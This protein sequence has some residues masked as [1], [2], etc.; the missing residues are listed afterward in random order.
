MI[1]VFIIFTVIVFITVIIVLSEMLIGVSFFGHKDELPILERAWNALTTNVIALGFFSLAIVTGFFILL[2]ILVKTSW[3]NFLEGIHVEVFGI[4]FDVIVLVILSSWIAKFGERK[5]DILRYQ[6]EIEDFRYWKSDESKFRIRG[7]IKRLNKLQFSKIDLD[8]VDISST[9]NPRGNQLLF[10]D[11]DLNE[12]S[13]LESDLSGLNLTNSTFINSTNHYGKFIG[14]VIL[15]GKFS[16][17]HLQGTR[18]DRCYLGGADFED[19]VIT[20]GC[21]FNNS[22]LK[23]ASFTNTTIETAHFDN[24]VVDEDF[25]NRMA[26]SG[27][28]TKN[29]FRKYRILTTPTGKT[30]N[31]HVLKLK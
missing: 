7:N 11:I 15:N 27:K 8:F 18:F 20:G 16:D 22:I 19:A 25:L 9:V 24:A 4:I 12:A 14:S 17:S 6:E 5:R 30:T 10:S 3:S 29:A 26:A 31:K 23:S 28:S 21:I 2:T 13:M 1:T